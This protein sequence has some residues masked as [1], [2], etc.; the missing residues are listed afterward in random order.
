[1]GNTINPANMGIN[2]VGFHQKS[3]VKNALHTG[4]VGRTGKKETRIKTPGDAL[5]GVKSFERYPNGITRTEMED[6]SYQ[7]AAPNG[8]TRDVGADGEVS[9]TLPNGMMI[10]HGEDGAKTYDPVSGQYSPTEMREKEGRL[11]YK[12]QDNE[13]NKW[14]V[15]YND[16]SFSVQNKSET[17]TQQVETDGSIKVNTKTLSRDP[18]S[19]RFS[20]DKVQVD[21]DSKGKT[22]ASGDGVSNV[23]VNNCAMTFNARDDLTIHL[24][25]PYGIPQQMTGDCVKKDLPPASC[26]PA[27]PPAPPKDSYVPGVIGQDPWT[28]QPNIPGAPVM[29]PSGDPY[30]SRMTPSGLMR[31]AE[32]DGSMFISLPNG[33]VM[34]QFSD[35]RCEAFDSRN[36]E[37]GPLPVTSKM[38]HN[39]H[40]GPETRF[41]FNDSVGNSWT[42]YSKSP[43]FAVTSPDGNVMQTVDY[44][45]NMV[46]N[47]RTYPPD[48]SGKP[49]PKSHH[50][51]LTAGGQL[52]TFGQKGVQLGQKNVVFAENGGFTNY[53]LPYEIP[54][55]QNWMPYTPPMGFVPAGNIPVPDPNTPIDQPAPGQGVP[56]GP[57]AN[58]GQTPPQEPVKPGI[59]Q[60]VKNF[61]NGDDT[62]S[63]PSS[64]YNDY[65]NNCNNSGY[66]NPY[67]G[68][69]YSPGAGSGLGKAAMIGAGIGLGT[70]ALSSMMW[71]M[72]MYAS[73]FMGMGYM[74]GMGMGMGM[75]GMGLGLASSSLLMGLG[76]Y[77]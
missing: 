68:G 12:F 41:E 40:Q 74:P 48:S 38:V 46:I 15:N 77:Y 53:P 28:N 64:Q 3:A 18:V 26:M 31:K 7:L 76:C 71:P 63:T 75:L 33:I 69:Y 43:D 21:I 25:F 11:D 70:M 60:R 24:K 27:Q 20:Q 54:S 52:N 10:E 8:T 5:E 9:V 17:L 32:P 49:Q 66:C 4:A 73:P 56:G 47:A 1:M 19:G 23:A 51:L 39:P 59:W 13:G 58:P 61:F 14:S 57:E 55:D 50:L 65:Y 6:G 29:V 44:N 35:G 45:G 34:S 30:A 42:V 72:G 62:N 22:T 67:P 2:T 36:P 16:L 37:A